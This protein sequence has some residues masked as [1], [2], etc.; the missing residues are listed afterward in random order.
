MDLLRKSNTLG[1]NY[2][3]LVMLLNAHLVGLRIDRMGNYREM[4][5][6]CTPEK[7]DG[8]F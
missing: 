3:V 1:T 5:G 4:T 7:I 8:E 2:V 6:S